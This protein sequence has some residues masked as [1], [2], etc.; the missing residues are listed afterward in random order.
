M[1][2]EAHPTP[3]DEQNHMMMHLQQPA[4]TSSSTGGF[5]SVSVEGRVMLIVGTSF[6]TYCEKGAGDSEREMGSLGC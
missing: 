6:C 2:E 3:H 4:L 5:R 1:S